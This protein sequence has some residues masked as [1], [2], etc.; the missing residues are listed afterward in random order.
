MNFCQSVTIL[1]QKYGGSP[2][3]HVYVLV[4]LLVNWVGGLTGIHCTRS[5]HNEVIIHT[6]N[7]STQLQ[8]VVHMSRPR[9]TEEELG[10]RN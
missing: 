4:H 9:G 8:L 10:D 6:F 5:A 2:D 3:I 7:S 1:F